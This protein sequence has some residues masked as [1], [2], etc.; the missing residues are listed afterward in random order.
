MITSRDFGQRVVVYEEGL[1]SISDA[2]SLARMVSQVKLA[3]AYGIFNILVLHKLGDL[4][5]AGD[6]GSKTR[7]QALSLLGDSD[8]RVVYHQ[9][10]D[11]HAITR[12]TLGLTARETEKIGKFGVGVGLWKL[13]EHTR[14]VR[15]VM[16]KPEQ[17]VFN[18]DAGMNVSAVPAA[19]GAPPTRAE[20]PGEGV[21][22]P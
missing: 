12:E 8:I 10:A 20:G 5:M 22:R 17:P 15:V 2:G 13:G 16:T 7:A 6:V 11:Q 14:V 1:D 9:N 21:E 4:D 3:R 18:T 19:A